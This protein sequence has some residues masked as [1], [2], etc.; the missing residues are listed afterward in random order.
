MRPVVTLELPSVSRTAFGRNDPALFIF[1]AAA[2]PAF[3]VGDVHV[4]G[5]L[6]HKALVPVFAVLAQHQPGE[7]SKAAVGLRNGVL[8]SGGGCLGPGPDGCSVPF[9]QNPPQHCFRYALLHPSTAHPEYFHCPN[10]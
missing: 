4:V 3:G 5:Q 2:R 10:R 7:N 6:V 1:P 9:L 8:F